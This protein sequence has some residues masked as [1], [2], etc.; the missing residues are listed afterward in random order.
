MEML[1]SVIFGLWFV[2]SACFYG[3]MAKRGEHE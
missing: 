3:F 1:L 2:V